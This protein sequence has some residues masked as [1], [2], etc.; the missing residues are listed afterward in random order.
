MG[1]NV[2]TNISSEKITRCTVCQSELDKP[3]IELPRFPITD[4]Y[5]EQRV[6]AKIGY[7]DQ[8]FHL[9]QECGHG[10]LSTVV[11]PEVLYG[12]AYSFRTSKSLWGSAKANDLFLDFINRITKNKKFETILEI[13]CNDLYLLNCL[14][15]KAAKLVGV[16]P[17]LKG[18]EGEL[19][20]DKISVIGD[21]IENVELP[22]LDD[23]LILSSH[24]MEHMR[25]PR[26][27]LETLLEKSTDE[28]LFIFQF[29][30]FDTLVQ[31]WR[32]DQIYNHHLQYFSRHSF[33]HLLNELGC[34]LVDAEV[35]RLYWGSLLVAFRKSEGRKANPN[36]E[37]I[38][39]EKVLENY[40]S[41]K[42]R[43]D[44]T[45]RYLKSIEGERLIG[46]G[47]GLQLPVLAYHLNNDFSSLECVVDDD[48][49]KEGMFYINL[50][51]PI[52]SSDG[53]NNL[54]ETNIIV[55]AINFTRAIL[56]RLIPL[57]PKRIILPLNV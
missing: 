19:T 54:E 44:V 55:T 56:L 9:C 52:R 46:Y 31:E 11:D 28:T 24:L 14:K 15:P 48:K 38:S 34:E 4:I 32:F 10:Q 30:G 21:F 7:V 33:A 3:L 53:L 25:D 27:M 37:K 36:I 12:H 29:P 26:L 5:A 51:V 23:A 45:N 13:G 39:P 35:N 57:N 8:N 16:D 22:N 50:P 1:I 18:A 40:G 41:F 6:E 43:L 49:N 2:F 17:V 20:D 42:N 47:A